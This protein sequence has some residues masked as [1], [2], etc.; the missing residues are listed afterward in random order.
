ML[1]FKHILTKIEPRFWLLHTGM[2]DSKGVVMES[3]VTGH[4]HS[5]PNRIR[6]LRGNHVKTAYF[7]EKSTAFDIIKLE[8]WPWIEPVFLESVF[9][10]MVGLNLTHLLHYTLSKDSKHNFIFK[11]LTVDI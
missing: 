3:A 6:C 11:F 1:K 8:S 4:P 5:L 2:A 9:H 10:R 7:Y